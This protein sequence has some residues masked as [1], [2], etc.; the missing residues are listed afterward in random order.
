MRDWLAK[1][2]GLP[3]LTHLGSCPN[4]NASSPAVPVS[5]SVNPGCKHCGR[6]EAH[7]LDDLWICDDCYSAMG[8]CCAGEQCEGEA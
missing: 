5:E 1:A 7:L 6:A 3:P 4:M 2:A 8:S